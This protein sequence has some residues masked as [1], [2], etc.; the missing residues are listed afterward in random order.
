MRT[1]LIGLVMSLV[2]VGSTWA[3]KPEPRANVE[4][5][6]L[7]E[8]YV[9]QPSREPQPVPIQVDLQTSGGPVLVS[10]VLFA[11]SW[12]GPI[13]V[14]FGVV[15]T[16]DG[17]LHH[18]TEVR[19]AATTGDTLSPSR[20][21]DVPAG[22]HTFGLSAICSPASAYAVLIYRAWLIAYELPMEKGSR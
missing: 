8:A 2:L 19:S 20:V 12:E 11:Y 10:V 21:F 22:V 16:V 18:E 6:D 5:V 13:P 9:C 1:S 7:A 17:Q 3:G 4:Q 15:F 14:S